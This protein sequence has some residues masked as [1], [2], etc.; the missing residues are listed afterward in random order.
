MTP[1]PTPEQGVHGL[2][3]LD[4]TPPADLYGR[5]REEVRGYGGGIAGVQLTDGSTVARS[6]LAVATTMEA[7]SEGLAGLRLPTGVQ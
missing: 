7:R 5:G 2:R 1:A 6:V 3:G 4:G